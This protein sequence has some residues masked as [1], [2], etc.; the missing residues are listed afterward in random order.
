LEVFA[1]YAQRPN[2][3]HGRE[4]HTQYAGLWIEVDGRRKLAPIGA[5]P[6]HETVPDSPKHPIARQTSA[7][8]PSQG[9]ATAKL[10]S[11]KLRLERE[12]K[13]DAELSSPAMP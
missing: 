8:E 9:L 6:G 12:S 13:H 10:N 4:N 5:E 2:P 11:G 1:S 7:L 3:D